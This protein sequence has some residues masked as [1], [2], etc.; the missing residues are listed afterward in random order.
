ML[1]DVLPC[2]LRLYDTRKMLLGKVSVLTLSPA[3]VA[4]P[5]AFLAWWSE[6]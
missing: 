1:V 4:L 5:V 2:H 3:A 6:L